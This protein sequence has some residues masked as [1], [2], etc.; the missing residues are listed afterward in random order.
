MFDKWLRSQ[1]AEQPNG[2]LE[3]QLLADEGL[4]ED[5]ELVERLGHE[6]MRNYLSPGEL[7]NVFDDPGRAGSRRLPA[8]EQVPHG[9]QDPA[10]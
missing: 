1:D 5:D 9:P 4:I 8:E 3:Y 10:W 2:L 6:V 7:A